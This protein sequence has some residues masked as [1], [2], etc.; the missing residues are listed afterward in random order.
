[1]KLYQFDAA[2][3]SKRAEKFLKETKIK[4]E[5]I[6]LNIMVGEHLKEPFKTMNPFNCIPFLE[7]DNGTVIS[8]TLAICK[9]LE[10]R[11]NSEIKLFGENAEEMA[12]IEM[13]NRR[14]ENDGYLPLFH[15]ARNKFE[16]FKGAVIPGTRTDFQQ[17]SAV[18]K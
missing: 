10:Q 14:L 1:M 13:W 18:T 12:L 8:E 6:Q 15:G 5:T 4:V 9:Y 11:N 2:P 3:S 7:L 16:M 17:N